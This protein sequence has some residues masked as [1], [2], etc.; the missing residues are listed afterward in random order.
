MEKQR[1]YEAVVLGGLFAALTD[2]I[3]FL[4]I[5]NCFCCL[6]IAGGGAVALIYLKKMTAKDLFSTPELIHLGLL[7]GLAGAFMA[8]VIHYVV[9]RYY[10]NWQIEWIRNMLD[11]MEE[12]PPLWEEFY[13]ELQSP[14]YVGFAGTSLLIRSLILF[15]VFSTA[16]AFVTSKILERR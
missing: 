1:F 14:E 6:G 7:T 5:V 2:T 3:P 12:L 16:G 8:F 15:P 11:N 4:N 9:F 13:D 10:G